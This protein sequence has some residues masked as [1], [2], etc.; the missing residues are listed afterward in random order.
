MKKLLACALIATILCAA[1]TTQIFAEIKPNSTP[2]QQKFTILP[3]LTAPQIDGVISDGEYGE[4]LVVYNY[5][6]GLTRNGSVKELTQE[7]MAEI[8]ASDWTIYI[9]YDNDYL[10]FACTCIDDDFDSKAASPG[11]GIWNGDSLEVDFW[12]YTD[13]WD[14]YDPND[15]IRYILGMDKNGGYWGGWAASAEYSGPTVSS[16]EEMAGGTDCYVVS[17]VGDL[18]TY[19]VKFTWQEV[20]GTNAPVDDMFFYAQLATDSAIYTQEFN[21]A[22]FWWRNVIPFT[23]AESADVNTAA[24]REIYKYAVP[25]LHFEGRELLPPVESETEEITSEELTTEEIISTEEATSTEE[26]T[27]NEETTNEVTTNK[28]D[29]DISTEGTTKTTEKSGCSSTVSTS[30]LVLIALACTPVVIKKKRDE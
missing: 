18:F 13:N 3:T 4:A 12:R 6:D 10:Y 11:Y 15:K 20:A 25:I 22:Q 28:P 9:T 21:G 17:R 7:Q 23:D 8:V 5:N 19:E 30:A 1:F 24:G 2:N 16:R 14:E 26:V 29:N 27:T